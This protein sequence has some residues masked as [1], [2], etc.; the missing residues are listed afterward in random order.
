[1][2]LGRNELSWYEMKQSNS[3]QIP[4]QLPNFMNIT[5]F[6]QFISRYFI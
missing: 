1:M 4:N 6:I 5:R 2:N 3:C